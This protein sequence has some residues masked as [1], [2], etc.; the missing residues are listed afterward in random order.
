MASPGVPAEILDALHPALSAWVVRLG[1]HRNPGLSSFYTEAEL[2]TGAAA[3]ELFQELGNISEEEFPVFA[4]DLDK[5]I[6][7]SRLQADLWRRGFAARPEYSFSFERRIRARVES[8]Q[9]AEDRHRREDLRRERAAVPPLPPR[10]RH[11]HRPRRLGAPHDGER[12]REEHEAREKKKWVE[13]LQTILRELDA[14]ILKVVAASSRPQE[15]LDAHLGGR[16][17]A[18]LAARVRAWSRYRVWLRRSYQVGH[19]SAPQHVLDYLLD[20]RSEPCTRGTLSA[21]YAAMRFADQML[22]VPDDERWTTEVNVANMARSIIAGAA[23]AVGARSQGPA[24]APVIGLLALLERVVCQPLEA[25]DVRMLSWWMLVSAWASLRYDDHR[26]LAP[27]GVHETEEGLD[28]VLTR[29]KT[30]GADKSVLR[31]DCVIVRDAWIREPGWLRVGWSLWKERAPSRRDYFLVQFG[32]ECETVNRE[33]SYVEYAGRMRGI[34]AELGDGEAGVLGA[35]A[36]MHWRPH[37]W[38][39]FLPSVATAL[40]ASS[41]T[42]RWLSAWRAKAAESYVRTSKVKTV[43]IQTT[44]AQLLRLHLGKTDPVG[45][46]QSLDQLSGHLAERGIDQDDIER[47]TRMLRMYPGEAATTTLW[48]S[49]AIPSDHG[50]GSSGSRGAAEP[51]PEG[52]PPE[53]KLGT[54]G[55]L[56]EEEETGP[57]PEGYVV[58]I[59]RKK[60]RRCLHRTGLCYRRPGVHYRQFSVMGNVRPPPSEYDDYCRD[61]WRSGPPRSGESTAGQLGSDTGSSRRTSSSSSS[62]SSASA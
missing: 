17:A 1:L 62:S 11:G 42:L 50:S 22:G 55:N 40:G 8:V 57:Q 35:D 9:A 47:I 16:R 36:A 19:P 61:C 27:E 25:P 10:P 32:A 24:N 46:R 34:L 23:S 7:Y 6:A 31:R 15:L 28:L 26:G 56:S 43:Q 60:G 20:R 52:G 53:G 44:T 4:S 49:L 14:P 51:S 3:L 54:A 2:A 41:D 39:S 37:S 21:V 58:A 33:M 38:R 29:T 13:R 5:L 48:G 59:S 45:E 18:T 12:E 30:T